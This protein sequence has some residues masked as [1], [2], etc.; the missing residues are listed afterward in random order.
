MPYSGAKI[1]T[2]DRSLT[3]S[4]VPSALTPSPA[5]S[6]PVARN[7]AQPS[8]VPAIIRQSGDRPN[9]SAASSPMGPVS[10]PGSTTFGSKATGTPAPASQSGQRAATGS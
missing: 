10:C 5:R 7:E 4:V 1:G 2:S 8:V 3:V 9:L 6:A